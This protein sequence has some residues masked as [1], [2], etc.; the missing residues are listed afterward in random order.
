VTYNIHLTLEDLGR[1][2][3]K[4]KLPKDRHEITQNIDGKTVDKSYLEDIALD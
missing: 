1:Q 3:L 4:I 2:N